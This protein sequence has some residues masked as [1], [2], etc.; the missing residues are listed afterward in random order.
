MKPGIEY[1]CEECVRDKSINI[2]EHLQYCT[3]CKRAYYFQEEQD[4]HEDLY[5]LKEKENG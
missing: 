5:E 1:S 2:Y 3:Y 4:M